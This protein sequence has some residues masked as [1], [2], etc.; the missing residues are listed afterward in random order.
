MMGGIMQNAAGTAV[1]VM[2][3]HAVMGMMSGDKGGDS[4][5]NS[6]GGGAAPQQYD[7]NPCAWEMSKF[8]ECANQ[9]SDISLCTAWCSCF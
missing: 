1:G 4:G 6:G 9:Q 5:G 2:G 8:M 7:Q 3:A